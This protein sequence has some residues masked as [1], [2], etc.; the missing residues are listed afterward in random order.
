MD[1]QVG[2]MTLRSKHLAALIP[3]IANNEDVKL[4][5]GDATI[6]ASLIESAEHRQRYRLVGLSHELEHWPTVHC[7]CPPL[8]DIWDR[9]YDPAELAETEQWIVS[10][11]ILFFT[12]FFTQLGEL[13]HM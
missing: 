7:V 13:S 9:E 11:R 10:V 6:Q 12:P 5:F 1:L 3:D 2:Q 8:G 4:I